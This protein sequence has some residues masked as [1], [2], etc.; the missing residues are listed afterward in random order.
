[1]AVDLTGME[2]DDAQCHDDPRPSTLAHEL[3]HACGLV[4]HAARRRNLMY[5]DPPRGK[6]LVPLQR[7][8]AR[9]SRHVTI[10]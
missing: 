8:I 4:F 1:V 10:L 9:G 2:R 5:P 3:G 7:A 6:R